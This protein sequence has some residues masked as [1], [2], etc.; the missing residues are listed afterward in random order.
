MSRNYTPDEILVD[1]LLLDDTEAFEELHH[2]YCYSLYRYCNEKLNSA[3]DAKRMTRDIF[4][5]LW[6]NR[7]HLPVNFSIS[8]HLYTEVRKAVVRCVNEKLLDKTELSAIEEQIIPGFRVDEL[9][10][11]RK[12]V[13][14]TFR[15]ESFAKSRTDFPW[16][17]RYPD[18]PEM[19]KLRRALTNMLNFF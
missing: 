6:E 4:I 2:R 16:W 8:L 7:K 19:R 12:P 1:R 3:E 18:V 10:K 11:A 9:Q 15:L 13:K 17:S 5:S 14:N